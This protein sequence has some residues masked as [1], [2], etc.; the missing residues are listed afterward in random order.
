MPVH[1]YVCEP[2]DVLIPDQYHPSIRAILCCPDCHRPAEKSFHRYPRENFR[3]FSIDIGAGPQEITSLS[4]IRKIE[5]DSESKARNHEGQQVVFRAFSQD[6]SNQDVNS[7]RG[8]G[9][10]QFH[11]S[12]RKPNVRR[13]S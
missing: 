5:R 10:Q 6:R 4:Q 3:S 7:L 9:H 2:C 8:Q 1:D 11:P 12:Q 13:R